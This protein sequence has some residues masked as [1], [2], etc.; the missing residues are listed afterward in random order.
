VKKTSLILS[1][2]ALAAAGAMAQDTPAAK[3]AAATP[4]QAKPAAT[5]SATAT[6][7]PA[8]ADPVVI[9][10]GT[11]QIH[12][13][14]FEAAINSIPE[15]YRG[16]VM[17]DKRA[18]AEDYI[19]MKLLAA[20]GTKN[21]LDKT[22]AVANQ[23]ALM[24]D[25]LIAN[26]QIT[27]IEKTIIVPESEI[28]QYYDQH[29]SE[30]E[31]VKARHILIAFKGSRAAQPNKKELTDA[32]AKAKAEVIRAKLVAGGDFAATAKAESD[33]I[34]SGANGG[35]L[36]TFGHGQMV[37]E[38]DQAAFTLKVGEISPVIKT[39]FGYHILQVQERNQ[40]PLDQVGATIQKTMHDER[41]KE[42][43]EGMK[44]ASAAKFDDSYFTAAIVKF[45]TNPNAKDP[46]APVPANQQ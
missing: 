44:A 22:P 28:K 29:K 25:N 3:P 31:Q 24:R 26:A 4:A 27:A 15:Q 21:G 32:E 20:E 38:F 8:D 41:M 7:K 16:N 33:D 14:E 23:L 19:R 35:D 11:M 46:N 39:E 13:S 18:F 34:G 10:A 12:K 45:P 2:L 37:P 43:L 42:K 36:G 30:F 6:A 9:S 40:T 17:A 1:A 5:A